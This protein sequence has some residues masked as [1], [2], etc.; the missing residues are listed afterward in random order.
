MKPLSN[1]HAR[2]IRTETLQLAGSS[3]LAGLSGTV[4]ALGGSA[5]LQIFI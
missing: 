1:D 2:F 5:S 3:R 4:F